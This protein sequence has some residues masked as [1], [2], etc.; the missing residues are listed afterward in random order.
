MNPPAPRHAAA[1]GLIAPYRHFGSGKP[2]T[3]L[4]TTLRFTSEV[5]PSIELA[6]ALN[7]PWTAVSSAGEKASPSHP[8]PWPPMASI[9]SSERSWAKAAAA[10]LMIEVA[11]EGPLL[12][13]D[14]AATRAM[15]R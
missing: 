3:R 8:R 6:F 13:R 12:A 9:I 1:R 5:P 4:E 15:V 11:A 14:S 2:R 7:Q 10:Y